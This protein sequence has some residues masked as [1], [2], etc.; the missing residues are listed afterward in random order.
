MHKDY[1]LKHV[2]EAKIERRIEVTGRR[3]R[4][5]RQLP[6]DLEENRGY[7]KMKQEALDCNVWTTCFEG[8]WT[9]LKRD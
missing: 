1:L 8:L 2:I 9:G 5:H 6:N 3:E 4:R 7:W